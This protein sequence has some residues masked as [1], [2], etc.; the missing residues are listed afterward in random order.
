MS[1]SRR[2][3]ARADS[4][5]SPE[6]RSCRVDDAGVA[7]RRPPCG[8]R[9][10]VRRPERENSIRIAVREARLDVTHAWCVSSVA[11][12]TVRWKG[13]EGTA[14]AGLSAPELQPATRDSSSARSAP[15][16]REPLTA[17]GRGD[18]AAGHGS[19]PGTASEAHC[20]GGGGQRCAGPAGAWTMVRRGCGGMAKRRAS[21]VAVPRRGDVVPRRPRSDGRRR[22]PKDAAR[23]HRPE[24]RCKRGEP[25]H[26]RSGDH[27]P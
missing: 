8:V 27:H 24:R 4:G 10:Q 16:R 15:P 12:G 14:P 22:D 11:Y 5:F 26:D 23:G 20:G 7:L 1:T 13:A 9:R 17:G 21:Q 2:S 6:D 19:W 25:D 3:A 18:S